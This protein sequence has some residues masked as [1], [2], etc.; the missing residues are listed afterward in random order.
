MTARSRRVGSTN[1]RIFRDGWQFLEEKVGANF[2]NRYVWSPS[3]IDALVTRDRD[4]D[5]NGTLDER[6]FA[7][8]DA[9]FNVT[10]I[11]KLKQQKASILIVTKLDI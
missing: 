9:N 11:A 2:K 1:D 7:Q 5:A 6:L 4:T 8:H 10:A 3:Y